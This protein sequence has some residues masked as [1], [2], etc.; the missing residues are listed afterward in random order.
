MCAHALRI[1][2]VEDHFVT[3]FALTTWLTD[4][5]HQVIDV[6]TVRGALQ[7]ANALCFDVLVS[8]INLPD[9]NGRD[10]VKRIREKQPLRAIAISGITGQEE[11]ELSRKAGFSDHLEKP[12]NR[13]TLARTLE[14]A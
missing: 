14:A 10:L 6:D 7:A 8:D 3:R 5:G 11:G 13:E 12:L 9:G 4:L 2:L 1:L